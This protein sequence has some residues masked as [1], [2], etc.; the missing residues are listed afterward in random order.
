[1][2]AIEADFRNDVRAEQNYNQKIDDIIETL[3]ED[4]SSRG[5]LEFEVWKLQYPQQYDHY[6]IKAVKVYRIIRN[7]ERK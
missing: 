7:G 6:R 5:D 2:S 1:M 4:E 3:V